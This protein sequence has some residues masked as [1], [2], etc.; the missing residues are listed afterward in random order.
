MKKQLTKLLSLVLMLAIMF[1]VT[2]GLT[3]TVSAATKASSST[4]VYFDCGAT[5]NLNATFKFS[6]SDNVYEY[7]SHS[8]NVT[9]KPAN[10]RVLVNCQEDSVNYY[11]FT[12]T[13]LGENFGEVQT[14]GAYCSQSGDIEWIQ[15]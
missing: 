12:I 14:W 5:V 10:T 3:S 9:Y 1:V 2:A 6:E 8:Y 7:Y 15:E 13:A 4:T 11:K